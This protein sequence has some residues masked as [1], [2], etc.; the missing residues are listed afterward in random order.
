MAPVVLKPQF[1]PAQPD[2]FGFHMRA[3]RGA[4]QAG[5]GA[6][7]D[8]LAGPQR[9]AALGAVQGQPGNEPPQVCGG[10]A[11]EYRGV[12]DGIVPLPLGEGTLSHE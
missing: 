2:H 3:F 5:A 12:R 10:V 8:D 9:V 6:G 11:A 4:E 1:N 7:G